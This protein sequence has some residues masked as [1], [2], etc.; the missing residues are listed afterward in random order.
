MVG[1]VERVEVGEE[2]GQVGVESID[3]ADVVVVERDG[4]LVDEV[5]EPRPERR[6]RNA[7]LVGH[8]RSVVDDEATEDLDGGLGGR[9]RGGRRGR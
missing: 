4:R 3:E 1:G 7:F 6:D 8:R 9:R 5:F 2:V